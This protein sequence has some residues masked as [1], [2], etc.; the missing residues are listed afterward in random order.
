M[1]QKGQWMFVCGACDALFPDEVMVEG[2]CP[3]CG[4]SVVRTGNKDLPPGFPGELRR[5]PLNQIGHVVYGLV[6]PAD[7]RIFYVGISSRVRTRLH[8]HETSR[9]S[10]A[11]SMIQAATVTPGGPA[12][13]VVFGEFEDRAEA[14]ALEGQLIRLLPGLTNRQGRRK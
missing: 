13:A 5:L 12:C 3:E 11:W 2:E 10:A 7:M 14:L 1:S 9:E 6:D 8:Q 4:A